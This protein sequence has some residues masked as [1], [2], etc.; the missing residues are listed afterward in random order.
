MIISKGVTQLFNEKIINQKPFQSNAENSRNL[1]IPLDEFIIQCYKK[2]SENQNYSVLNKLYV[3]SLH[4]GG[5]HP[6]TQPPSHTP[7][8]L[9]HLFDT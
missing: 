5:F 1:S 4:R 7:V 6:S 3:P 8:L 2:K 9:S